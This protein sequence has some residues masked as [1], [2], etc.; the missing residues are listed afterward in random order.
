MR[1]LTDS[2]IAASP[3]QIMVNRGL[4]LLSKNDFVSAQENFEE[5]AAVAASALSS[6]QKQRTHCID[7]EGQIFMLF[8]R[9][10]VI[11]PSVQ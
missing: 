6:K 2:H 9:G 4:L 3:L 8:S 5:A 7:G 11:H 1:I 10:V